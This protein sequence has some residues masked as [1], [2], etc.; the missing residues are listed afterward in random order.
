MQLVK[1][2]DFKKMSLPEIAEV[3]KQVNTFDKLH[4]V[5]LPS[6]VFLKMEHG[7]DQVLALLEIK[8]EAVLAF[9]NVKSSMNPYQVETTAKLILKKFHYLTLS[10]FDL[11]FENA[12]VGHYG[13]LYSAIDGQVIFG[14]LEQYASDR[15]DA[16][17]QLSINQHS[18]RERKTEICKEV[19][20]G[21]K[22]ILAKSE[23]AKQE[24]KEN[25]AIAISESETLALDYFDF[26]ARKTQLYLPDTNIPMI[27][28]NER[29]FTQGGW[30]EYFFYKIRPDENKM[31]E[32]ES[33][34]MS[35]EFKQSRS[36]PRD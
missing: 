14:W 25:Q 15:A 30:L 26:V 9:F 8:I 29:H 1:L 3:S 13:K 34:Q 17:E 11:C 35:Q 22:T 5:D 10:D 12:M 4:A 27:V 18:L 32:F 24:K 23:K 16:M 33:Q 21:I 28:Y 2:S 19:L 20:E 36:T 31:K 7:E 6:L